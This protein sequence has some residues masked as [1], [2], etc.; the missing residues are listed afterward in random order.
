VLGRRGASAADFFAQVL[1]ALRPEA[2]NVLCVHA[3]S[4]GRAHLPAL[5]CF[6]DQVLSLGWRLVPLGD[7]LPPAAAALPA[8]TVERGRLPGRAS[9]V[10]LQGP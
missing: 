7:L 9:E 8:A 3:E 2:A 4:E 6:I 5:E 1:G 10:S